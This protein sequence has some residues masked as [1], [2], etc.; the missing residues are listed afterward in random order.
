M[1]ISPEMTQ[2]IPYLT[3]GIFVELKND[4][5]SWT[6]KI[7]ADEQELAPYEGEHN[8]I[9]ESGSTLL[10]NNGPLIRHQFIVRENLPGIEVDLTLMNGECSYK[11][12]TPAVIGANL[13]L[14]APNGFSWISRFPWIKI[15]KVATN[16]DTYVIKLPY[17]L[18]QGGL[19]YLGL[20]L[21]PNTLMVGTEPHPI[22]K[23]FL[24]KL[25][26]L[27]KFN[28]VTLPNTAT[29]KN[30]LAKVKKDYS[31]FM[32]GQYP[33]E[34]SYIPANYGGLTG[35][36]S[37]RLDFGK[38]FQYALTESEYYLMMKKWEFEIHARPQRGYFS[39]L[40]YPVEPHQLPASFKSAIGPSNLLFATKSQNPLN[41]NDVNPVKGSQDLQHGSRWFSP[42][43]ELAAMGDTH[44]QEI[45]VWM[46]AAARL[47]YKDPTKDVGPDWST[48]GRGH[49][50]CAL[51]Q[52]E[53]YKYNK[54]PY[55]IF[56]LK[57]FIE[58]CEKAQTVHGGLMNQTSN[59]EATVYARQWRADELNA[60]ILASD[61]DGPLELIN[62]LDLPVEPVSQPPYEILLF[63]AVR[64]ARN[65]GV[66]VSES[67]MQGLGKFIGNKARGKG[68]PSPY[69]RVRVDGAQRDNSLSNH[70]YGDFLYDIY[71]EGDF[72]EDEDKWLNAFIPGGVNTIINSSYP[73]SNKWNLLELLIQR[74]S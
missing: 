50:W 64:A 33:N 48:L 67:L 54:Y 47:D 58:A 7:K 45:L 44:A 23:D 43:K 65:I 15:N 8:K 5:Y 31:A 2:L 61:P 42:T 12:R 10:D 26:Y 60:P 39:Y 16:L 57:K 46:A 18:Y 30:L 55:P 35:G 70:Y 27:P 38:E 68:M 24:T 72:A 49:A 56:W 51:L 14:T 4:T 74:N 36:Q 32:A 25:P 9:V 1:Q 53:S 19:L 34:F 40:G 6:G 41:F 66:P 17:T 29:V 11:E 3:Q 20:A 63:A 21:V 69:Y 37:V 28:R 59:K 52:V 73:W 13:F 22:I 62:Y 71:S